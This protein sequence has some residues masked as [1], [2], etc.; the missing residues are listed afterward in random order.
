MCELV[1][2]GYITNSQRSTIKKL[3]NRN[4]IRTTGVDLKVC[5]RDDA[6]ALSQ[7]DI[8]TFAKTDLANPFLL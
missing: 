5:Q 4:K 6:Q 7:A 3:N 1:I 2:H 8:L